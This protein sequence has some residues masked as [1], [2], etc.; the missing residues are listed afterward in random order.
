[1]FVS[2]SN[3]CLLPGGKDTQTDKD[4]DIKTNMVGAGSV[5]TFPSTTY[6]ELPT[7]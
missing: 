3:K 2:L 4:M 1:M 7:A 6:S 5:K